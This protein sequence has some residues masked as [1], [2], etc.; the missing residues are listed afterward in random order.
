V[1]DVAFLTLAAIA[2]V[3]FAGVAAFLW[4]V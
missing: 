4:K 1:L 2:F 3:G